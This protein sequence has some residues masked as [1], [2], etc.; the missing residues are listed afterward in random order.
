[1]AQPANGFTLIELILTVAIL[2]ILMSIATASYDVF[3]ANVRFSKIK[4]DM[5]AIAKSALNDYSTSNI[6]APL[7]FGVMPSV[8]SRNGELSQ[9]PSPPCPGWYYSW[10]DWSA[11]G[12]PV[13]Q[14]TLRRTNNTLLWGYCLDTLG[15]AGSCQVAD[16]IFGGAAVQDIVT[17]NTHSVYCSE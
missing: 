9:W 17:L 4:G 13:T 14:V 10:E 3:K 5:D 1:M 8:W 6:W 16:P 11:F 7:S 2:A 15:G 12:Y